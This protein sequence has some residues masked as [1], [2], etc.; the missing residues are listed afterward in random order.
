M[1]EQMMDRKQTEYEL[2]EVFYKLL[3][4]VTLD[5]EEINLLRWVVGF[6]EIRNASQ[7]KKLFDEHRTH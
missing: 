7:I 4:G 5:V 6:P 3:I 2:D 1:D